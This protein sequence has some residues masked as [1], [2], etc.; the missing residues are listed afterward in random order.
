MFLTFL[1]KS[2]EA[3]MENPHSKYGLILFRAGIILLSSGIVVTITLNIPS[4]QFSF[5]L[6]TGI[7]WFIIIFGV[8]VTGVGVALM[9]KGLSRVE[10]DL[11][12]KKFYYLIGL[13]NQTSEPPVY[14]LPKMAYW[15][16]ETPI[17]LNIKEDQSLG[18]MFE[19]LKHSQR[20]IE[21]KVEQYQAKDVFFAGLARIP[22]LFFIGYS[23]RNAH[24]SITLLDYDQQKKWFT[25]SSVEDPDIDINIEYSGVNEDLQLSDIAVTIEFTLEILPQELPECL[26]NSLVRIKTKK[27]HTHN[28][29]KS[30]TA[31]ERVVEEIINVLIRLNKKTSRL[32]LFIATQST[33]AF[34]LGRRYLDGQIGNITV[35]NYNPIKKSYDWAIS[36]T[37]NELKLE[38]F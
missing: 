5:N 1:E 32:H 38:I 2:Q 19:D 33:A 22:C 34:T 14:A 29:I 4:I 31:L 6:D 30:Q 10:K 28:L 20:I 26:Q 36:L 15:Y 12:V 18:I 3:K 8:L 37:N 23:F 11:R 27:K 9:I 35:Y 21:D 16:H 13:K 24:S 17:C 7:G 25:L